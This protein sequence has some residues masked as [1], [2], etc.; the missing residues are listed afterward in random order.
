MLPNVPRTPA[1]PPAALARGGLL[2]RVFVSLAALFI[3]FLAFFGLDGEAE[4]PFRLED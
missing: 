2:A 1:S 4:L 3:L